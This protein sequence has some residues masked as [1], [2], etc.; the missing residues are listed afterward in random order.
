M[1]MIFWASTILL[2]IC[3]LICI[4]PWLPNLRLKILTGFLIFFTA[5]GFY[6]HLGRSASL[7]SYYALEKN[8]QGIKQSEFR[9]LL[10]EFK[11]Q[12][13]R[14]RVRLEDNPEDIDAEWQLL[15]V[16][17]IKALQNSDY[18]RAV[19]YWEAAIK[20]IPNGSEYNE[21]KARLYD[22]IKVNQQKM[23]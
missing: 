12:E 20:K 1:L 23:K 6:Y 2:L 9:S 8:L 19:Q 11:K 15:D 10:I 21:V 18:A 13:Y 22:L 17:A 7:P 3:A 14:L 5:Y 16:L 4:L